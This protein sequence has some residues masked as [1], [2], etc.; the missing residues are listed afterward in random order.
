MRRALL[1]GT[2][3]VW[4]P[5]AHAAPPAISAQATPG[6]GQAP[7][8]VTLTATGTADSFSWNLGDGS[9]A[10]GRVV[11]HVY[12]TGRY[13]ATVTATAGG[14]T[15]QASVTVTAL[16]LSLTAPRA[17]TYGRRVLLAGRLTPVL[18]RARV[19]L[20]SGERVVATASANRAG[21]VR[22]Q[23]RLGV[24]PTFQARFGAITS[25]TV[26]L[27]IRPALDTALPRAR[28]VGQRLVLRARV[29]PAGAGTITARVWRPRRK[30]LTYRLGAR[31]AVGLPSRPAGAYVVRVSV[32]PAAGFVRTS[33]DLR[34]TVHV[35]YLALGSR[36]PSVR[37]LERRLAELAYAV[38]GIDGLYSYDTYD[39]VLAFQ[40]VNGLARTGRVDPYVWRRLQSAHRPRPRYARGSH[41]EVDKRR[42]VLLEVRGGRVLRV[43]HVSTGATGNTPVGRWRVYRKVVGWDWVLWFPMYFLRG[44]AIHGYPSVPVYPAS[45]GCVRVP[46]W[47][48][49]RLFARNSYGQTILVY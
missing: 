32:T 35:P 10:E 45:H 42:Q 6:I 49:P 34:A 39:A 9:Q 19:S 5:A 31:G 4:A 8:E 13:T 37:A 7:L 36:G 25:N 11:R 17:G 3:F 16:T 30:P 18:P 41:I 14:E 23:P 43:V 26:A 38:R 27:A 20:L 22:F 44:F 15:A 46:M 24:S 47:V 21:K 29:R 33:R 28:M 48:A 1:L 40:K 12:A 2:F